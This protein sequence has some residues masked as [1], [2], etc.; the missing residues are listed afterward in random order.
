M[1]Q[2]VREDEGG[3][4]DG[5]NDAASLHAVVHHSAVEH[6]HRSPGRK[7]SAPSRPSND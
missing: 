7:G 4:E 3:G 5:C 6:V 2:L 1:P